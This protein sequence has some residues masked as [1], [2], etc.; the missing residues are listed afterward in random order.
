MMVVGRGGRDEDEV[1]YPDD[2]WQPRPVGA[3]GPFIA[4]SIPDTT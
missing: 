2:M 3:S 1:R 4:A